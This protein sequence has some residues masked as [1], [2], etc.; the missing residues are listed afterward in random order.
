MG[1][2]IQK[3]PCLLLPEV[4]G[5][6]PGW[7]LVWGRSGLRFFGKL[8]RGQFPWCAPLARGGCFLVHPCVRGVTSV[9]VVSRNELRS[10]AEPP[11]AEPGMRRPRAQAPLP[12]ASQ[13]PLPC[14][15]GLCLECGSLFTWVSVLFYLALLDTWQWPFP[16]RLTCRVLRESRSLL[17]RSSRM[18]QGHSCSPQRAFQRC[19]CVSRW[20]T[21]GLYCHD[22]SFRL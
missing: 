20:V 2:P 19:S 7:C 12:S 16:E 11:G 13:R 22:L 8:R 17:N 10:P 15:R 3:A 14:V 4:P 5:A 6:P 1:L 18:V 21:F 9:C